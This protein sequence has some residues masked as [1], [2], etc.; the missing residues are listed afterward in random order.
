MLWSS[1]QSRCARYAFKSAMETR[2]A[3]TLTSFFSGSSCWKLVCVPVLEDLSV[4]LR[5]MSGISGI[6]CLVILGLAGFFN[7]FGGSGVDWKDWQLVETI[8][9]EWAASLRPLFCSAAPQNITR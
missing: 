3:S 4:N 1:G 6:Q 7:E 9:L 2:Y 8:R 5:N